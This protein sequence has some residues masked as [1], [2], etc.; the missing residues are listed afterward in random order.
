[1]S[2]IRNLHVF[3]RIPAVK[4]FT[5][6]VHITHPSTRQQAIHRSSIVITSLPQQ[7][8]ERQK[9][10]LEVAAEVEAKR[11]KALAKE[12]L[13]A[14]RAA[15][16][17]AS[18]ED[19]RAGDIAR[20]AEVTARQ[21]E[22]RRRRVYEDYARLQTEFEAEWE[23]KF[24]DMVEREMEAAK[25]WLETDKEAPFKVQ[26]ELTVLKRK[27]YAAPSPETVE[28]ERA[29]ADPANI[30]FAHMAHLLY[31]K[32]MTLEAFFQQHDTEVGNSKGD[33]TMLVTKAS[34]LYCTRSGRNSSDCARCQKHCKHE[35]VVARLCFW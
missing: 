31:D 12:I 2:L 27:F 16:H 11:V 28:L 32:N 10:Q 15:A 22:A 3:Y 24:K 9:A 18:I 13:I 17:K 34:A 5:H 21:R 33:R 30:I 25:K 7:E 23:V 19:A 20:D 6:T 14:D 35:A 1:M 8:A 26:K 4:R 29:L